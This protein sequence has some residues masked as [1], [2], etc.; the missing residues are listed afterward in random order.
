LELDPDLASLALVLALDPDLTSLAQVEESSVDEM[1]MAYRR[2]HRQ[3]L[4]LV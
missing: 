2:C 4:E 1:G 3:T